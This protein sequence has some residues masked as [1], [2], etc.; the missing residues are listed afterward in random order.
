MIN[1]V[2]KKQFVCADEQ[3]ETD[4]LVLAAKEGAVTQ[5]SDFSIAVAF[6]TS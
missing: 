2:F 5:I 3:E 4:R 1:T 6:C